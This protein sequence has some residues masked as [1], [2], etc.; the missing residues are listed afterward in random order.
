[1]SPFLKYKKFFATISL[2]SLLGSVFLYPLSSYAQTTSYSSV[3]SAT[4]GC[5]GVGSAISAGLSKLFDATSGAVSGAVPTTDE[6]TKETSQKEKCLDAIGYAAAKVA[7]A[8]LT[9]TTIN[10]INSGF[11]GNPFYIRNENSFYLSLANQEVYGFVSEL[12][13]P[14]KYPFGPEIAS[15]IASLYECESYDT[16]PGACFRSTKVFT[17]AEDIGEN[18]EDFA[19]DFSVGGW[20]GWLAMT[21]NP[22]NNPVG[23]SF[24][25]SQELNSRIEK[26]Q[27][28]I[29]EEL[30]QNGGF[31]SVKKCVA[32][33]QMSDPNKDGIKEKVLDKNGNPIIVETGGTNADGLLYYDENGQPVYSTGTVS[34]EYDYQY[35]YLG[36]VDGCARYETTTPGS[37]ISDQINIHLGSSVRQLELADEMNESLAAVFDALINKLVYDGLDALQTGSVGTATTGGYGLN[38]AYYSSNTGDSWYTDPSAPV[39]L[40]L[41]LR[42]VDSGSVI[43]GSQLGANNAFWAGLYGGGV[44]DPGDPDIA[45]GTGGIMYDDLGGD[46][47]DATGVA[48][49]GATGTGVADPGTDDGTGGPFTVFGVTGG[50]I[51]PLANINNPNPPCK[52]II[53][54]TEEYLAVLK[55][56]QTI[57]STQ[58][59]P[60]L[61]KLDETLPEPDIGWEER[62][63][64]EYLKERDD[65]LQ[66]TDTERFIGLLYSLPL[67]G[68]VAGVAHALGY[69]PD[70]DAEAQRQDAV[71]ALDSMYPRE[72]DRIKYDIEHHNL[73]SATVAR[74]E[75]QKI[76]TYESVLDAYSSAIAAQQ[77]NLSRLNYI[78]SQL[79]P[80][81]EKDSAENALLMERLQASFAYAAPTLATQDAIDTA[82]VEITNIGIDVETAKN[83]LPTIESELVTCGG[84]NFGCHTPVVDDQYAFMRSK[85]YLL[86]SRASISG[87]DGNVSDYT[88]YDHIN[89]CY[90]DGINQISNT[91]AAPPDGE[92]IGCDPGWVKWKLELGTLQ[93]ATNMIWVVHLYSKKL[94]IPI[95][96][97][98]NPNSVWYPG[99]NPPYS[100]WGT[101]QLVDYSDED[102]CPGVTADYDCTAGNKMFSNYLSLEARRYFDSVGEAKEGDGIIGG[103]IYINRWHCAYY[104]PDYGTN[105][106][107]TSYGG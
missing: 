70:C 53:A 72:V 71:A 19:N 39:D 1:M 8:A 67:S 23:F 22:S 54:L 58:E 3:V 34:S 36:E 10:Y 45:G 99:P 77:A 60:I 37:V 80:F 13:D 103:Q 6:K 50:T 68:I 66:T 41:A 104:N 59:L 33:Y 43:P 9:Q 102:G 83:I 31:L 87:G 97:T 74:V 106:C 26:K 84:G 56:A 78:N 25:A 94:I 7:L 64:K 89:R 69:C 28:A 4:L 98:A 20:N 49:G 92:I 61:R 14:E 30:R 27:S 95:D 24:E 11:Q 65:L 100:P 62:L 2:F 38:D 15:S 47:G 32:Y 46:L 51:D 17:L 96:E 21:Q 55:E 52:T 105:V 29:L 91:L 16:D 107:G 57:V 90:P 18:W 73:P 63:Y 85:L 86:Q 79:P 81:S 42:C 48:G 76:P 101:Y 5:T 88:V 12:N 75:T 93:D 82:N 40:Y 35:S 44:T